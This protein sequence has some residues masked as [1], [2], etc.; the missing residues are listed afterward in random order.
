MMLIIILF[1]FY[2]MYE[3]ILKYVVKV[4]SYLNNFHIFMFGSV[5]FFL[6]TIL[7]NIKNACFQRI[8]SRLR[9]LNHYWQK[10]AILGKW[11]FK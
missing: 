2:S 7:L 6:P 3:M 9:A 8:H 11:R 1:T 5:V 4:P 10:K